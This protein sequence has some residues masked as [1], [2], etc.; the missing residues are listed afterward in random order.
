MKRE[1]QVDENRDKRWKIRLLTAC[2]ALDFNELRT[3]FL[4]FTCG[5]QIGHPVWKGKYLTNKL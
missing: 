3:S 4:Y 2:L 1:E 5:P